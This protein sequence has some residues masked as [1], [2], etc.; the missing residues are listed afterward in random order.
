MERGN[1]LSK[2][3]LFLLINNYELNT[4][5]HME[6]QIFYIGFDFSINKPAAT[7]LAPN[8]KLFF[9]AWPINLTKN[10]NEVYKNI[11]QL[12]DFINVQNRNLEEITKVAKNESELTLEHTK[13]SVDLANMI[14]DDIKNFIIDYC[15]GEEIDPRYDIEVYIA[16]EGL[17]FGSKGNA[18]LNLATY[19]A[20][21]L[22]KF[23]ETF[24]YPIKGLY[25]YAPISVK[26]TA[27][28]AGKDARNKKDPMIH[29]F[30]EQDE[31][32][33]SKLLKN[34]DLKTKND[35]YFACVD[36]IVDSYWVLQTM[37]KKE[38]L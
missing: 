11:S 12:S 25:T 19:K 14:L 15:F 38:S 24:P 36:D 27:N 8:K 23:Y 30:L 6:K 3:S 26:S 16:S 18:T 33:L 31:N 2:S 17:S 29:A 21:L 32:E 4:N 10:A 20:V 37:F 7:I 28:C 13:R 34:G 5:E 1:V 35:K 9:F 22:A